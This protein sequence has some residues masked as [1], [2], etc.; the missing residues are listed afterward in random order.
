METAVTGINK[1]KNQKHMKDEVQISNAKIVGTELCGYDKEKGV[2]TV[3]LHLDMNGGCHNFGGDIS[4][5]SAIDYIHSLI[6][7]ISVPSWEH[8]R[9]KFVRVKHDG[10]KLIAVGHIVEEKWVNPEEF[11]K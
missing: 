5:S 2:L 3:M 7:C 4:G 9:G 10:D 8:M 11:L 1:N 6:Q